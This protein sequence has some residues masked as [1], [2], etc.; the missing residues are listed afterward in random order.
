M[1]DWVVRLRLLPLPTAYSPVSSQNGGAGGAFSSAPAPPAYSPDTETLKIVQF[2][3]GDG[4][5]SLF[6]SS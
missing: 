1:A 4:A 2:L 6:G 5:K 3:H